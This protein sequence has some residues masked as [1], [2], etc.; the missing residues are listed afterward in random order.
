MKVSIITAVRNGIE[1]IA[2][3][4]DSVQAQD[5][6]CIEHV[7]VDGASSDGTAELLLGMRGGN[8]IVVSEPDSGIYDALNKGMRRS[9]GD[10]IGVMHADDLFH[11]PAVVA[12]VV[13]AMQRESVDLVY[14]D[15]QYVARHDASTVVRYW[16]SGTFRRAALHRGWM[17]PHPAVFIRRQLLESVG[18]YDTSYRIA[19][20]YDFLL[21][22]LMR[23]ETRCAYLPEVLVRMRVG[24]VSNRSL[25]AILRKS[26]E[27]LR[28]IRA[29]GAGGVS[30]LLCKNLRKLPQ[31]LLRA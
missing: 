11:G 4:I 30:V 2:D 14:G 23:R 20:D 27:D 10:V 8:R 26:R 18:E 29:N 12:R 5:Y 15:L 22:I 13:S 9:T 1:T 3:A 7:L 28:A 16:K 25:P 19:A 21:R 31:F 6:A 24:G 17:P